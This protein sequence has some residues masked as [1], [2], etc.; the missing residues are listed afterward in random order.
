[1]KD[2]TSFAARIAAILAAVVYALL[3]SSVSYTELGWG[4]YLAV[5]LAAAPSLIILLITAFAVGF[6][7]ML[8]RASR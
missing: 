6:F 7:G 1:M 3:S 2:C 4:G 5:D 8:R